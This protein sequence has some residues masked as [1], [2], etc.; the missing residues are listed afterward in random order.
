M[1]PRTVTCTPVNLPILES[2]GVMRQESV[3]VLGMGLQILIMP[4]KRS[5]WLWDAPYNPDFG[6]SLGIKVTVMGF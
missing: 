2:L 1:K 6:V 5:Q 4:R 3:T